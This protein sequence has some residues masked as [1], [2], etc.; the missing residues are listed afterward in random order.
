MPNPAPDSPMWYPGAH[1]GDKETKPAVVMADTGE[2]LSYGEL[3]DAANRIARVFGSLGLAPGDHVAICAEN[4]V[5]Y[6]EVVWG[7][8]YAGLYYTL[9]STHLTPDEVVHIVRDCE[10]GAVVL[11]ATTAGVHLDAV[12]AAVP[13]VAVLTLDATPYDGGEELS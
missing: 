8:H 10:A 7:A 9:I 12:R 3:D 5:D 6:L 2:G 13:G 4:R 11:S 1:R